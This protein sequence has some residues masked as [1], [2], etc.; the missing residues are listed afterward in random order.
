MFGTESDELLRGQ[1]PGWEEIHRRRADE[2]GDKRIGG[3]LVQGQ[4]RSD[5]LDAA[6]VHHHDAFPHRHRLGLVVRDVDHRRTEL[7]VKTDDL[8]THLDAHL[9]VQIGQRLVEEEDRGLTD[10]RAAERDA[11]TL[12]ARQRLGKPLQVVRQPQR[13]RGRGH[14]A[15]DFRLG[16]LA[17]LEREGHVLLHGHVR[18]K[19]V[20]LKDHRNVAVL[21]R[22]IRDVLPADRDRSARRQ[23]EA[24]DHAQRR[25]LATTRRT[26]QNEEFPV[27][28]RKVESI[29]RRL[30]A[31][32]ID[33]RHVTEYN[34]RHRL[35]IISK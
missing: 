11:L 24:R 26:H 28:D 29:H 9:R 31:A 14:T 3:L 13:V 23:F 12:S 27:L 22:K 6:L 5:L 34:F 17:E 4:R 32:R 33:L 30:V 18:I 15:V 35:G 21:R 19:R 8:R 25:R 10:D 2:A 16:E 1:D 20:V 7:M